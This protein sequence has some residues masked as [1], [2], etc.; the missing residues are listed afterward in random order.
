MGQNEIP[1]NRQEYRPDLK[2]NAGKVFDRMP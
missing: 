2:K 1:L